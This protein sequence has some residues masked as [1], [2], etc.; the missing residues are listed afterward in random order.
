[1]A[2]FSQI[3]N[4]TISNGYFNPIISRNCI[5]TSKPSTNLQINNWFCYVELTYQ[6]MYFLLTEK[7]NSKS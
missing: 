1:M 4:K 6:F 3:N 2:P 7:F 5:E